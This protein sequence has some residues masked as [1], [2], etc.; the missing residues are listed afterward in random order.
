MQQPEAAQ[1]SEK[2]EPAPERVSYDLDDILAEFR[3]NP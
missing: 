1:Q 3:D 2:A